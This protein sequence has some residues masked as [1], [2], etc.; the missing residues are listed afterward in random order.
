MCSCDVRVVDLPTGCA[1]LVIMTTVSAARALS[2]LPLP[3]SVKKAAVDVLMHQENRLIHNGNHGLLLGGALSP[4]GMSSSPLKDDRL[5]PPSTVTSRYDDSDGSPKVHHQHHGLSEIEA[6]RRLNGSGGIGNDDFSDA[7]SSSVSSYQADSFHREPDD[8]QM[9][10]CS[11]DSELSVGKEVDSAGTSAGAGNAIVNM[12]SN[13]NNNVSAIGRHRFRK[14]IDDD[15]DS[16]VAD[17]SCSRTPNVMSDDVSNESSLKYTTLIPNSPRDDAAA[18]LRFPIVRPSPTRLQEEFLR[19][20]QLYAE[21]LMKHQMSFMAATKGLNI[22]G[23]LGKDHGFNGRQVATDGHETKAGFRPHIRA[24]SENK[25]DGVRWQQ[26]DERSSQSPDG[27]QFRGIHSHLNAISKI[28]SALGRDIVSLT[29]PISSMT[30]RE[31]SQS[32]PSHFNQ[33]MQHHH[34]NML[35][36]SNLKFSIDNILKP[37]FGRRITDPL[38]KRNKSSKKSM[39]Q[40]SLQQQQHKAVVP[41]K[42]GTPIDLTATTTTTTTTA[43]TAAINATPATS[44]E[45]AAAVAAPASPAGSEQDKVSSTSA[46]SS[47]PMVWPA[48]V[49][50]T[51]YS[52]RPSSGMFKKFLSVY[53]YNTLVHFISRD[54]NK[55][56]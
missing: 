43:A 29:S 27:L 31:S 32:P 56:H 16:V 54:I 52:D 18:A 20:S 41:E 9:S 33:L 49:Y 15:A 3:L 55:E 38:L 2:L 37:G 30:S 26:L 10:C 11:D 53:L 24:M 13:N 36:D 28:T 12:F 14:P 4:H 34:N 23:T 8:D 44:P 51:R 40:R 6:M 17:D 7:R 5:S 19:N 21:E 50:C 45:T 25:A 48:W 47:S 39:A 46:S 35:N 42:H 22:N 1:Q